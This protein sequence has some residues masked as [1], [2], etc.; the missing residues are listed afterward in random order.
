MGNT[1][2]QGCTGCILPFLALWVGALGA[3]R[4]AMLWQKQTGP[5][6][7]V[8]LYMLVAGIMVV[9][10]NVDEL[11]FK[12]LK[13]K[14]RDMN[15]VLAGVV[16]TNTPA[17]DDPGWSEPTLLPETDPTDTNRG[18]FGG[19]ATA[20][21]RTLSAT[22]KKSSVPDSYLV[23][24]EIRSTISGEKLTGKAQFYLHE[25]FTR[26]R[27][28][29]D[30]EPDGF[31]RYTVSAWGAFTVGAI[32]DGGRTQLELDLAK[33]PGADSIFSQR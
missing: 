4:V 1:N 11:S 13:L 29:V 25:T 33:A 24:M 15:N 7:I 17:K 30:P 12:D 22:V 6:E 31:F 5:D 2:S 18:R 9:L 28:V 32:L 23:V 21:N 3:F 20:N 27:P 8:L 16:A 26:S 19:L 10:R 14:M